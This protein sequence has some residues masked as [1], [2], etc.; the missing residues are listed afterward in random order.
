MKI[1]QEIET[2]NGKGTI[3]DVEYYHRLNGGINRYGVELES[4]PFSYSPV[5]YFQDELPK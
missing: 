5:Y 3:V 4:N 2:P 1:G